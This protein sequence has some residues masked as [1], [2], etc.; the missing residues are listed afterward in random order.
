MQEFGGEVG[1]VGPLDGVASETI[2]DELVAVEH[3]DGTL[4]FAVGEVDVRRIVVTP[5]EADDDSK[6][7]TNFRHNLFCFVVLW[8]QRYE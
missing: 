4:V 6:E 8:V 1:A 2:L 7:F 3:A 5:V